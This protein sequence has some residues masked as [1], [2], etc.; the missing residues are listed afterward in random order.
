MSWTTA[1][2]LTSVKL[3]I[4][5]PSSQLTISDADILRLATEEL[6]GLVS[7]IV[8]SARSQYYE[9]VADTAITSATTYTLPYRAL[10]GK[11]VNVL[12]I[13]T[14]GAE[15]LVP[16]IEYSEEEARLYNSNSTTSACPVAYI[17]NQKLCFVR[18]PN[19]GTLRITYYIRPGDLILTTDAR[20]L[21]VVGGSSVTQATALIT[22]GQ[23]FD[24]IS[25]KPLFTYR[26]IDQT[27]TVAG[28]V[29]TFT[30]PA[31]TVVGD[32]VAPAGQSPIPQIPYELHPVL[33]QRTA[34]RCLEILGDRKGM[35]ALLVGAETFLAQALTLVAP[36]VSGQPSYIVNTNGPFRRY[37]G[38]Y[39]RG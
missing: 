10:A 20:Q 24:V 38:R 27:G 13:D 29:I 26:G 30:P 1:D 12:Y 5:A 14:N 22:T 32:W 33:T 18:P 8:S 31:D 28:A 19:G 16:I 37:G 34:A 11:I 36:R 4:M 39:R 23:E 7:P 21:T 6:L 9:T 35:E 15:W 17:R 25:N 2:L 3:K